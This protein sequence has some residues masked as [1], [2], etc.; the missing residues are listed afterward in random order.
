VP[1]VVAQGATPRALQF[2]SPIY[3][4]EWVS[5]THV[6]VGAGGGGQRFGMANVLA[7][8]KLNVVA[9][10][11]F[12]EDANKRQ[13]KASTN[14]SSTTNKKTDES[15]SS[16][17]N[18]GE[19]SSSN[20]GIDWAL[21]HA[22]DLGERVPWCCTGFLPA[23]M[24]RA[25]SKSSI[26]GRMHE[27]SSISPSK[28]KGSSAFAPATILLGTVI[29]SHMDSFSLIRVCAASTPSLA[30]G[31]PSSLLL[32]ESSHV[33]P[34][35]HDDDNPDKKC[36]AAMECPKHVR[37]AFRD[38][39]GG[40]ENE[41][42]DECEDDEEEVLVLAAQDDGCVQPF[43]VPS[44]NAAS[45]SGRK[46]AAGPKWTVGCRANDISVRLC[47]VTTT[48]TA[49]ADSTDKNMLDKKQS[50]APSSL[51]I[52]C[53]AAMQDKHLYVAR[54]H[55]VQKKQKSTSSAGL[56]AEW[57]VLQR[58]DGAGCGLG[59]P[60]MRSSLK[61]SRIVSSQYV[62]LIAYDANSGNSFM[63]V[64]TFSTSSG[65]ELVFPAATAI[66]AEGI[67]AFAPLTDTSRVENLSI[68]GSQFAAEDDD[69]N[70]DGCEQR[71][72]ETS[73]QKQTACGLRPTPLPRRWMVGTVDG[74]IAVIG[75]KPPSAANAAKNHKTPSNDAVTIGLLVSRPPMQRSS[76]NNS[77]AATRRPITRRSHPGSLPLHQEPISSV[78][79]APSSGR[80]QVL[81]VSTDI[82]QK[83][84]FSVI[85]PSFGKRAKTP[86]QQR[87]NNKSSRV[88]S[89]P[90]AEHVFELY[91]RDAQPHAATTQ[92]RVLKL[93]LRIALVVM[94]IGCLITA[95][96][97]L[98]SAF[99]LI[100]A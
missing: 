88:D 57:S 63:N 83:L 62:L 10:N 26:S 61:F 79:V 70:A 93:L 20:K 97:L 9:P 7:L 17:A 2:P 16:D 33:V 38:G 95:G 66:M 39:E 36:V 32:L 5:D 89:L 56:A 98:Q 51:G 15:I 77:A 30:A 81:V 86:Q 91:P 75:M 44:N 60:I 74:S 87:T 19:S 22:L 14:K 28:E 54:L 65:G 90:S 4:S 80:P 1:K 100:L 85:T 8:L 59:F 45:S 64:G 72:S 25:S 68:T 37:K 67:T 18:D 55:V 12:D 73:S 31:A 21:E 3:F 92:Q 99:G 41:G 43:V 78:S 42:E 40:S 94:L 96:L 23:R 52:V 53:V 6:I 50:S 35:A 13:S 46:I 27:D 71:E 29:S 69:D 58:I 34:L 47:N 84:I 82:A 48:T 76:Q 49:E 11:Q 24:T